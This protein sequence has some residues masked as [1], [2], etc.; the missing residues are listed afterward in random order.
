M[1]WWWLLAAGVMGSALAQ[2]SGKVMSDAERAKR[3]AE[4]VFSFIKFQTVKR[5][6]A[7]PAAGSAAAASRAG[8]VRAEAAPALRSRAT[9]A[10]P[11]PTSPVL[12]FAGTVADQP[13]GDAAGTERPLAAPPSAQPSAQHSPAQVQPPAGSLATTSSLPN[14]LGALDAQGASEPMSRRWSSSWLTTPPRT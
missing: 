10:E 11:A 5:P 8:A 9:L 3:D 7:A 1:R 2:E 4:K 14:G 6:A 13:H 12:P